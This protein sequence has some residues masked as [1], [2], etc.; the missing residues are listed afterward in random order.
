M[1]AIELCEFSG[2]SGWRL[3]QSRPEAKLAPHQVRLEV[4][5][6]S[7]NYRDLLVAK[8][9]YN[10]SLAL[11]ALPISDGA[12]VIV[13]VGTQVTRWKV[14]DQVA[15]CFFQDWLEGPLLPEYHNT[16][17]GGHCDGLAAERVVL[18]QEGL[19]AIAPGLSLAE[20]A[21]LPCAG[22]TAWN[23]LFELGDLKPGQTVLVQGTGGVSLFALQL[24]RAAGARVLATTG[25]H[26]KAQRLTELGAELVVNYNDF[27][28]WGEVILE[29]TRGQGV[30]LV[31][32]VGGG[33]TLAQSLNCVKTGGTI[34]AIGVL[35][36]FQSPLEL[37]PLLLKQVRLQG[38]FV[39]SRRMF[40][41]LNQFLTTSQIHPVIDRIFP[42]SEATR[43]LQW[44]SSGQHFGKVVIQG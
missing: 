44:L 42:F 18:S 4:K 16:A 13:E 5:A 36:G 7:L 15:A 31:I 41:N 8:G 25:S 1:Q 38:V 24:A 37:F 2:P 3:S 12:G 20:A 29:A 23:A 27:P 30:D 39:G 14:G 6:L 33:E 17:L 22:L 9:L 28:R 43:A 19:V 40:E 10:P 21:C 11:P 35:S 32:E 26:Q 34:G